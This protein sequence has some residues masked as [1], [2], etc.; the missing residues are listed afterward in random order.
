MPLPS[1]V[2]V[3]LPIVIFL[4]VPHLLVVI[5][6]E[7]LKEVPLIVLAVCSFVAVAE[8]PLQ[9]KAFVASPPALELPA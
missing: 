8:L 1:I 4:A 5:L 2:F 7:P 9:A 3:V 6:A